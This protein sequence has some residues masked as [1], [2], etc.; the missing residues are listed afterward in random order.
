MTNSQLKT[1]INVG[2][3]GLLMASAT[4]KCEE[5]S[6]G[7]FYVGAGIGIANVSDDA[8]F[9]DDSSTGY[10]ALAGFHFTDNLSFEGTALLLDDFLA[11]DSFST[12]SLRAVAGGSGINTAVVLRWSVTTRVNVMARAGVLFWKADG[13]VDQSGNDMS[14]GMGIG[15]R[16]TDALSARADYDALQFGN[17]DVAV[18]TLTLEYRFGGMGK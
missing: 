10:K 8:V 16:L 7:R 5:Y 3:L 15:I 4:G 2:F 9:I 11:T 14:F 12:D 18:G 13:D 1:A 17:I 6:A